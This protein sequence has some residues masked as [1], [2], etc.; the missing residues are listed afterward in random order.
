MIFYPK[1]SEIKDDLIIF[2]IEIFAKNLKTLVFEYPC[3]IFQQYAS[4]LSLSVET[5]DIDAIEGS[6][7]SFPSVIKQIKKL[8]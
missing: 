7:K 2:D 3:P 6:M 1:W 5:F 4:D 8:V